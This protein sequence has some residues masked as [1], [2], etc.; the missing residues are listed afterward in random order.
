[1]KRIV[2]VVTGW[3]LLGGAARA[4][5]PALLNF[6]GSL[7]TEAGPYEG[8]ANVTLAFYPDPEEPTPVWSDT[9]EVYVQAGR[10]YV[11]LGADPMNPLP[12][13]L[14]DGQDLFL[15][16]A[17]DDNPE[18]T[19]RLRVTSVPFA[20]RAADAG[21]LG[22]LPPEAFA[23]AGHTHDLAGLGGQVTE[24][25]LPES[26]VLSAELTDL[27][28]GYVTVATFNAGLAG[29][30]D[31]GHGHT[32]EDVT[33]LQEALDG[34]AA[35]DHHHDTA[36]VNVSEDDS[37]TSDMVKDGSIGVADLDLV[38][39]QGSLDPRYVNVGEANSV[40]SAM[41]ANGTIAFADLGANGC[42]AGKVIKRDASAW[43]CGDDQDTLAGLECPSARGVPRFEGS[44]GGNGWSC[45]N[46]L[47]IAN[48][49]TNSTAI[50][51]AGA[52]AYGTGSEYAFTSAGT[53]GQYLKSGGAGAPTWGAIAA[54]DIPAG[55]THYIQNQMEAD[56]V[57]SF[58]ISGYGHI[59][60]E[61]WVGPVGRIRLH[62]DASTEWP[63]TM[64]DY[65]FIEY[66]PQDG[67]PRMRVG[68]GTDIPMAPVSWPDL[69][70]TSLSSVLVTTG[71]PSVTA[72]VYYPPKDGNGDGTYD[73]VSVGHGFHEISA[74]VLGATVG[75]G[76]SKDE[77]N[78]VF[79][80]YST[81][82]GGAGNMIE[83]GG[84]AVRFYA[85]I[86]G[87]YNNKVTAPFGV[88]GGGSGNSVSGEAAAV[89]GGSGNSA[90]GNYST[91]AGGSGNSASGDYSTVA[92]GSGNS[93]S[94]DYAFA[95]GRQA[96]AT[97]NGC[98]VWADSN[99]TELECA[100]N[101]GFYAR[102]SGGFRLF[103]STSSTPKCTLTN[104]DA[105]WFCV[106]DRNAKADLV[107][108][109][110]LDVLDRVMEVPIYTYR[111]K[112]AP[113]NIRH[114]GPM[115]QDFYAAFHLGDSD[116]MIGQGDVGG[117]ALAAV[118]GLRLENDAL[119][120]E[121][122]ALR[123]RVESLEVRLLRLERRLSR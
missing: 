115:A 8:P 117:V 23:E 29:K 32:V 35:A 2:V 118:Q 77:P 79:A 39:L 76:G 85:T 95:A 11:L 99:D 10:F 87:G 112:E 5:V 48:G 17:V 84:Q 44:G 72:A 74:N 116:K 113:P 91:V 64:S 49:G 114:M 119:R 81:I 96:K 19:P 41:I 75:G 106:S 60:N 57:A 20:L 65:G 86:A 108:V 51:T 56:Q 109:D 7:A 89:A 30:S 22:G 122:A 83:S 43:A 14:F 59:G 111:M 63:V 104:A 1:M 90:P 21:L 92:G 50:P 101:N 62:N 12:S 61:L 13:G 98:F 9:Q 18:M 52:V 34:K 73:S 69:E 33:G 25:Q 53:A 123:A 68:T 80:H 15:G 93:A 37:V 82:G 54:S 107:P 70:L 94:G 67:T 27:L 55:S 97:K 26:V 47:P 88:I 102:A 100:F 120:R 58:K 66:G 28:G 24:G 71:Q 38:A 105:T 6:T 36:Y 46:P 121:N 4:D 103:T 42:V 110:P 45:V 31:V 16:V 78:Q 40:N 3:V